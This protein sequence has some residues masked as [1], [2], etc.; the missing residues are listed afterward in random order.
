MVGPILGLNFITCT[1]F[2][3]H[4][5]YFSCFGTA[6]S[7]Y[8]NAINA[9]VIW[10]EY[11]LPSTIPKCFHYSSDFINTSPFLGTC[12]TLTH[13]YSFQLFSPETAKVNGTA[14]SSQDS[15]RANHTLWATSAGFLIRPFH[16]L[17]N[18]ISLTGRL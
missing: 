16:H 11:I 6:P 13:H 14:I 1:T 2:H 10:W 4:K 9:I 12:I 15:S 5:C 17:F 8:D 7:H 18:A 3:L